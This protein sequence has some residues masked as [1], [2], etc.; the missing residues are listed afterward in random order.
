VVGSCE[1]G[2]E[3]SISIKAGV[4]LD[5]LS[6]SQLLRK[7]SAALNDKEKAVNAELLIKRIVTLPCRHG[8]F[9]YRQVAVEGIQRK[10]AAL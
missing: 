6:R 7:D 8:G 4:F 10:L 9:L 2:N 3:P 5:Q 1:C